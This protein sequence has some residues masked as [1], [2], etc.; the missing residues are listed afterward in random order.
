MQLI[1]MSE[2]HYTMQKDNFPECIII[3][4]IKLRCN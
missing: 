3:M 1:N 2:E 4:S